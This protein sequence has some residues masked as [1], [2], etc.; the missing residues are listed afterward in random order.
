MFLRSKLNCNIVAVV[1][2]P[3]WFFTATIAMAAEEKQV[4]VR[5]EQLNDTQYQNVWPQLSIAE[6]HQSPAP[7][8]FRLRYLHRLATSEIQAALEPLGYYQVEVAAALTESERSYEAVYQVTPGPATRVRA[9][10]I[11]LRGEAQQDPA[12]QRLLNRLP[13]RVGDVFRHDHYERSKAQ[14]RS[15]AAERGYIDANFVAQ[16]VR[17][18]RDQQSATIWL[19]LDSGQRFEFG[20]VSFSEANVG[21]SLLERYV[22]FAPGDPFH[23]NQLLNLQVA[24]NQT[25]YFSR[26]EVSPRYQ[27][28]TQTQIP[29]QVLLEPNNRTR[30]RY[31]IGYGTDTGARLTYAHTRRWVNDRGHQFDGIVRV[32]EINTTGLTNYRIPGQSPAFEH[33]LLAFEIADQSYREQRSTLY[34][35]GVADVVQRP[36][37]QRTYALDWRHEVFSFGDRPEETSKFLLPSA[38]W[39]LIEADNRFE[40]VDGFRLTLTAKAAAEAVL[41]DT[42]L[43]QL[44]LAGKWV[45]PLTDKWRLLSRFELGATEVD[46]FAA[47]PPSLRFFAGGDYSVRAYDYQQLGPTNADGVVTGG[48]FLAVVSAEIDYEWRENWR[49]AMFIDA[50]NASMDTKINFKQGVGVGIRWISPIGAIRLDVARAIDEPDQPWRLSFTLGPDL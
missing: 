38:S 27:Q 24:L 19:T 28:A 42:N 11:E 23:T 7:N 16:R 48:K 45:K 18:D 5:V 25:D 2:L 33:Y 10:N 37:L 47:L 12:F 13:I 21:T 44:H 1:L 35:A 31:G 34:R 26:V 36:D 17:V 49:V 41:S 14:L 43:A 32:S 46:R 40:D 15:L 22:N 6:L 8:P 39:T 3:L 20:T 9:L 50:G 4:V 30:N 29:V